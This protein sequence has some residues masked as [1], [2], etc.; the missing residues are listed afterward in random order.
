GIKPW[1]YQIEFDPTTC[2]V[3]QVVD[4]DNEPYQTYI[5]AQ[6]NATLATHEYLPRVL[7]VAAYEGVTMGIENVWNNLWCSPEL[8][9][10]FV[11]SFDNVR[12]KSYFDLGNYVKFAPTERCL[13]ALGKNSIVKLH[14]KDF[15]LTDRTNPNGG[16]FVPCGLGSNDWALIRQTLDDIEYNGFATIEFEEAESTKL[17]NEQH[18]QKFKNFFNGVDVNDGV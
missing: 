15:L 17:T 12:I 4:G 9:A 5:D 18:V 13:R 2:L 11:H 1:D 8:Y 3:S 7:P 6:N 16:V 10:A 14:F